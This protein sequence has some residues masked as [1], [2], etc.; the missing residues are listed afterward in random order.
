MEL[1]TLFVD[2]KA[3][4]LI[5]MD[6][7]EVLEYLSGGGY[8]VAEW[9]CEKYHLRNAMTKD[10]IENTLRKI[11]FVMRDVLQ[12]RKDMLEVKVKSK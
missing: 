8:P 11:S 1:K 4:L 2:F 6:D 3:Q 5:D 10:K 12:R 9:I 7:V